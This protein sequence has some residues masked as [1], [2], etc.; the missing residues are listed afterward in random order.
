MELRDRILIF[1]KKKW[2]GVV[3]VSNLNQTFFLNSVKT[4]LLIALI[5]PLLILTGKEIF[6]KLGMQI[7][8]KV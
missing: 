5:V 4:V 6:L 1:L 7:C 3:F 2:V 8:F